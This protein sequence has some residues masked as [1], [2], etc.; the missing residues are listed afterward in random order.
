MNDRFGVIDLGSNTFHLLIV[1]KD[2]NGDFKEI[3]KE[4]A[5]VG[6]AEE[7]I[8][9]LSDDAMTRGEEA[10][11]MFMALLNQY[12]ITHYKAV[13]TAALRSAN[14]S[15]LFIEKI[16]KQLGLDIEIIAG[17]REAELIYKGVSQIADITT[18]NHVIMD[19][20]GGSVEFILIQ[21][22]KLSWSGSYDIGVGVLHNGFHNSDPITQQD[23]NVINEY[24]D[25][26]LSELA[27]ITQNL[28][29][30]NMIGAS[31]SFEVVQ[32]LNGLPLISNATSKIE[33]NDYTSASHNI[34]KSSIA[35]RQ[36]MQGLPSSRVKLIVVAM[37]LID[38]AMSI[39]KPDQLIVS[40]YALKE[41]VL[42]ELD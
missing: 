7:G 21:K 39:I 22:G 37:I 27:D 12:N 5:F 11:T 2:S 30:T 9:K 25:Q 10:L 20:G 23:Q 32:S 40:P 14:N 3:H 38:K 33:I 13:G 8:E 16:K 31:G 19:V 34:I 4:R 41:G 36:K 6:L 15:H 28:S 17:A 42:S 35:E 26:S 24:L 29:I 18:C 1:S